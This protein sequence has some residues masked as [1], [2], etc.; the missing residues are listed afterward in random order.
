MSKIELGQKVKFR[1]FEGTR[2]CGSHDEH[3]EVIGEVTLI[4]EEN[5]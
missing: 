2:V 3:R 4:N 1:P 5:Q